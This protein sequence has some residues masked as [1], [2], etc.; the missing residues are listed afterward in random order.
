MS[1]AEV[2]LLITTIT[3]SVV[4]LLNVRNNK[5]ELDKA[6]KSIADLQRQVDTDRKDIILIG[7]SLSQA[8]ADN[9]IL[10]E[11]FNKLWLEFT[12][13]T[14]HKPS[15][16]LAMLRRLYT[17]QYITGRLNPLNPRE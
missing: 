5:T 16:D 10:A 17:I 4:A 1:I 8:R 15:A 14:G 12:E 2:L 7:E 11:A 6:L 3:S 13:V 9:A